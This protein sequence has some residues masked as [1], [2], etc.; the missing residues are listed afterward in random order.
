M[1]RDDAARLRLFGLHP[2][3]VRTAGRA[4]AAYERGTG[5]GGYCGGQRGRRP[6]GRSRLFCRIRRLG[7]LPGPRRH[8]HRER[9]DDRRA[10]HR[11]LGP[12]ASRVERRPGRGDPPRAAGRLI[13]GEHGN[14]ERDGPRPV[15]QH[16]RGCGGEQRHPGRTAGGARLSRE[17]L[18]PDRGQLGRRRGD[19]PV[20][21]RYCRRHGDQSRRTDRG[22]Q[23]SGQTP[24]FLHHQV[25]LL[26]PMPWPPT[27]PAPLPSS[28][29]GA[30]PRTPRPRRTS[31]LCSHWPASRGR[32]KPSRE[33][34]ARNRNRLGRSSRAPCVHCPVEHRRAGP[35]GRGRPGVVPVLHRGPLG[36]AG[37]IGP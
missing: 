30:F 28:A 25:R 12:G 19:R 24:R 10:P 14:G 37:G 15:R 27:T 5:D 18:R 17:R 36:P 8:L 6:T 16:H 29:T 35:R 3:R 31:L 20:H 22:H 13:G 1:G 21:A 11:H 2:I 33:R 7:Q 34:R 23:R 32:R 4:V 9:G 26:Q